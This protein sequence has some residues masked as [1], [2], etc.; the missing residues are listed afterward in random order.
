MRITTLLAA[1]AT[2]ALLALAAAAPAP[3]D[4]RADTSTS[5]TGRVGQVGEDDVLKEL[6]P[7]VAG[8][9]QGI[10]GGFVEVPPPHVQTPQM[11]ALPDFRREYR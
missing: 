8:I 2:G 11:P 7:A 5:E 9:H 1:A 10:S 6:R 3:A 4:G